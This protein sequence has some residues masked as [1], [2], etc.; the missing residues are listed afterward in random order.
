M[1]Y[2]LEISQ[3]YKYKIMNLDSIAIIDCLINKVEL[4]AVSF[5]NLYQNK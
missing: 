1:E 5:F 3:I 4:Y 2:H